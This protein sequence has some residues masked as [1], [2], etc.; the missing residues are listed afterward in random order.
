MRM[1]F[2]TDAQIEHAAM[3]VPAAERDDYWNELADAYSDAHKDAY[4]VR[5]YAADHWTIVDLLK[6]LRA[7]DLVI[8]EEIEAERRAEALAA[9]EAV[10]PQPFPP[11]GEGW[12]FTPAE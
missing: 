1:A 4:G 3:K 2:M 11:C 8:E 5:G 12:A 7:F 9:V 6:D 10:A